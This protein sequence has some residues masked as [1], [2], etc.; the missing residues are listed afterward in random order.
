MAASP[1][2][3]DYKL[4]ALGVNNNTRAIFDLMRSKMDESNIVH[5][6]VALKLKFM[7]KT[8][9]KAQEPLDAFKTILITLKKAGVIRFVSDGAFMINPAFG[10]RYENSG[11]VIRDRWTKLGAKKQGTRVPPPETS[12]REPHSQM[13]GTTVPHDREPHSRL[14][15]TT[16]PPLRVVK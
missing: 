3:N 2:R 15:G 6:S 4:S 13:K 12:N 11:K 14:K 16:V 8:Q 10:L 5:L 9:S 1:Y 7:A